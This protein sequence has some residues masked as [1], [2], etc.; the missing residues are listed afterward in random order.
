MSVDR[1][2][3]QAAIKKQRGGLEAVKAKEA[4]RVDLGG[5]KTSALPGHLPRVSQLEVEA[6][7]K[8]SGPKGIKGADLVAE[9]PIGLPASGLTQLPTGETLA[10][11]DNSGVVEVRPGE[12]PRVLFELKDGEGICASDDGKY[13][14]VL[15]EG[16][17]RVRT[18]EVR[19]DDKGR[20]ALRDT[21]K[22]RKLPNLKEIEN[23]GWE[24]MT[25]LPKKLAGGKKDCIVCVHEASPRRIGIFELPDLD[26]FVT[27]KLP[28][29]AKELLPDLADVAVDPKT[30]HLF[31]VSDQSRTIVELA[32]VRENK[33]A[34][35]GLLERTELK[36]LSSVE[37][38]IGGK[39][40][41]EGL[42]F[43]ERGRL[44]V[45]LDNEDD[46]KKDGKALV[47]ELQR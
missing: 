46:D 41:P 5:T 32:I 33:A 28:K 14:Y 4:P 23:T 2:G 45:A 15:E 6:L 26:V 40:K 35:Q 38:P 12:K 19:R 42:H 47:L 44:W 24:G 36:V 10:I 27:L 16:K 43:D 31:I 8:K 1:A 39:H 34:T 21:D 3:R 37:L 13:V 7:G 17:R 11:S 18:L 22:D 9:V 30:G 29:A 20:V 25:F